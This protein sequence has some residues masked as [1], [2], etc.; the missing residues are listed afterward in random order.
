MRLIDKQRFE[1]CKIRD[2]DTNSQRW[3]DQLREADDISEEL[4]RIGNRWSNLKPKFIAE[5][6][7]K[8][9]YTE[10][11][12]AGTDSDIDHFWPKGRVKD[13][14]GNI[15]N[16][17]NEQHPGYWWKAYDI[18]NYR[19]SCIFANRSRAG[20]GKVDYFP[21]LEEKNR[22]WHENDDCDYEYRMILDP[23]SL[24]DV[25]SVSFEIQTAEVACIYTEEQNFNAY[26]RVRFSKKFLNLNEHSVKSDRLEKVI[27]VKKLLQLIQL[28][29]SLPVEALGDFDLSLQD[30]QEAKDILVEMCDRKSSFSAAIVQIVLPHRHR[31]YLADIL[32]RLDLNP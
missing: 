27:L 8:C 28:A 30:I 14:E 10:V 17:N 7:N 25:E 20:G 26:H 21:L 11:S 29:H 1:N 2:W 18:E 22:A 6:G 24:E 15:L 32:A 31:P 3:I 9:W 19:C 4:S 12:L 16:R 13:K 5:F 23:C